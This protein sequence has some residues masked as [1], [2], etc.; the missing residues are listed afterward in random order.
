V[1][2]KYRDNIYDGENMI[3]INHDRTVW[4]VTVSVRVKNDGAA[5]AMHF[6]GAGADFEFDV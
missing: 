5:A 4:G 6:V 1:D 2:H 3:D